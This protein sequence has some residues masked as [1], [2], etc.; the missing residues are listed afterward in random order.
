MAASVS[1]TTVTLLLAKKQALL[2][3]GENI[4]TVNGQTI[5]GSG[6]LST[7]CGP[8]VPDIT[9]NQIAYASYVAIADDDA[10]TPVQ[11]LTDDILERHVLMDTSTE[12]PSPVADV[13]FNIR[14]Q[15]EI[16]TPPSE[17]I[18]ARQ[19][20]GLTNDELRAAPVDVFVTNQVAV[21]PNG[22]ATQFET[23]ITTYSAKQNPTLPGLLYSQGDILQLTEVV[24]NSSTPPNVTSSIWKNVTTNTNTISVD[25]ADISILPTSGLTNAELR[26]TP[27]N[28]YNSDYEYEVYVANADGVGYVKHDI[29]RRET[30]VV[31]GATDTTTE[32]WSN[33]TQGTVLTSV[34]QTHLALSVQDYEGAST[35]TLNYIAIQD[36]AVNG[37]YSIDDELQRTVQWD[38]NVVPPLSLGETWFNVTTGSILT[39]IPLQTHYRIYSGIDPSIEN[40]ITNMYVMN[41]GIIPS[42]AYQIA[43]ANLGYADGTVQG[44]KLP[45]GVS[46][47]FTADAGD[48]LGQMAYDATGTEF[49]ITIVQSAPSGPITPVLN[50]PIITSPSSGA[51]NQEPSLTLTSSPFGGIGPVG[52]HLTTDWEVYAEAAD[53]GVT[54]PIFTSTA[55]VAN[56]TSFALS[57][58]TNG[59]D[60]FARVRHNSSTGLVS[61][62]SSLSSFNVKNVASVNVP[63]WSMTSYFA[64]SGGD[65]NLTSFLLRSSTRRALGLTLDAFS[66]TN[67]PGLMKDIE[68][69]FATDA[70]FTDVVKTLIVADGSTKYAEPLN[71]TDLP[72]ADETYK[73]RARR[74]STTG[75]VSAWSSAQ[76]V[77]IKPLSFMG[78]VNNG[79]GGA[80]KVVIGDA[81][82][83]A[84]IITLSNNQATNVTSGQVVNIS[85]SGLGNG[86]FEM[87]GVR[88]FKHMASGQFTDMEVIQWGDTQWT[89]MESAFDHTYYAANP[90]QDPPQD[91]AILIWSDRTWILGN[92]VADL[93]VLTKCASMRRM[94]YTTS[95]PNE[96]R[97]AEW[98]TSK[99]TNMQEAF[100]YST[101]E[102][103]GTG[104]NNWNVSSVTNF[105][106]MFRRCFPST[107]LALNTWN[108][109][110]ATNMSG[111]F[112]D[113]Q[114]WNLTA[115]QT[116]FSGSFTS[117]N[118][119]NV[120]DMSY[121]FYNQFLQPSFDV[122]SLSNWDVSNVTNMSYMF[123]GANPS[124]SC[125]TWNT[126]KVTNFTNMFQGAWRGRA[127]LS[128]STPQ[129]VAGMETLVKAAATDTSYMFNQAAG[130]LNVDMSAWNVSNVTNMSNMF[131]NMALSNTSRQSLSTWNTGKVIDMSLMFSWNRSSGSLNI[132]TWDVSKVTNFR[133]TF[134]TFQGYKMTAD[135]SAWNTS[136]AVNMFG[137]FEVMTAFGDVP[138]QG[139]NP[140]N[141]ANWDVSN[142]TDM[143]RMFL[144]NEMFNADLSGW[145]VSAFATEPTGFSE[146]AT[147]WVL[148][149]PVWGTC[150]P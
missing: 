78:I 59:E 45:P 137:M 93:P 26:A 140:G 10:N 18:A 52:T 36:D 116:S 132:G 83:G 65:G 32:T 117:W 138:N 72:P 14:T 67:G 141:I 28:V 144:D 85:T 110:S 13:W 102:A 146:N 21:S 11:Y 100:A 89:S 88:S 105:S 95:I 19:I 129:P 98:D 47:D 143:Y 34:D 46:L 84:K 149:K 74:I 5:L 119:S 56:L 134:E 133:N 120:T 7:C 50:A 90:S 24:D 128:D 139:F 12:P 115:F 73:V 20:S 81:L 122:P 136:G 22:P 112:R 61:P 114:P 17:D 145:C 37:E 106:N 30:K 3:S 33:V 125:A 148:P 44:S 41:A 49:I 123:V 82:P 57:G 111:M 127:G 108:T 150:P 68:F 2:V 124:F 91:R 69:Q 40:A 97:A 77:Y 53:V 86:L 99:V 107:T 23:I 147:A 43:V 104:I 75:V 27:V 118:T 39:A 4:K 8:K 70:A 51:L 31:F 103:I 25:S 126:A 113:M 35:E 55:S 135:L 38:N 1:L 54:A 66:G 48:Y 6:D 58:L 80:I 15:L 29:I 71:G 16:D 94:F 130:L 131:S 9:N 79:T 109:S 60:Y 42:G 96:F 101:L 64:A 63:V 121:M 76:D 92:Q 62:W 87:M 142:V